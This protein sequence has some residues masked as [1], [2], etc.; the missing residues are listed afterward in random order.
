MIF[1][2]RDSKARG[3]LRLYSFIVVSNDMTYIIQNYEFFLQALTA[4]KE[5]LQ[6]RHYLCVVL[7]F[8]QFSVSLTLF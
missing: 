6:V 7:L 3:F 2:L 5:K 4:M 8:V 1:R